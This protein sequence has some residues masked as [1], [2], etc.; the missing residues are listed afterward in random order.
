METLTPVVEGQTKV[1]K[2]KIK[3]DGAYITQDGF[4]FLSIKEKYTDTDAEA[5][6]S[7]MVAASSTETAVNLTH[8]DTMLLVN[9]EYKLSTQYVNTA[10][11]IV[12]KA[13]YLLRIIRTARDGIA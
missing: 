9:S 7:K 1:Y 4:V 3:V 5:I 12:Y 10:G 6:I 11:D 8:A 2:V 13:E